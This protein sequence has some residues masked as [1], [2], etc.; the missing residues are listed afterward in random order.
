MERVF[1][2]WTRIGLGL[3]SD[4]TRIGWKVQKRRT[5]LDHAAT[6]QIISVQEAAHMAELLD[7]SFTGSLLF[8]FVL[9]WLIV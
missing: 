1:S 3:D 5:P 4:W 6:W 7:S 9:N 8:F 2:D